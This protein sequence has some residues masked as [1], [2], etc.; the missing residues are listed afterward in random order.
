MP[1]R[2]RPSW[3]AARRWYSGTA[4]P[5]RSA[6]SWKAG[7]LLAGFHEDHQPNPRFLIDRYVPTFL[8]TYAV[9]PG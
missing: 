7:F 4:W 6:G 5:T 1:Q 8:A 2:W 9:K 3:R